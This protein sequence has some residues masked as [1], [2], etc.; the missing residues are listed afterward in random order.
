V[1]EARA[2]PRSW[3]AGRL[4][5]FDRRRDPLL[6][7]LA[8]LIVAV[9]QLTK[10]LIRST[11]DSGESWPGDGF[12]RIVHF[13][14]TGAAFGIFQDAGPLLAIT[15]VI[16][17]AAIF[18]YLFNPGFAHL[19]T[20]L[21][22][23]CMLGGAVGNLIDRLAA[24]EVVDFIKVSRWPAFNVADSAITIGVLLLLWATLR[25]P[26]EPEETTP[27]AAS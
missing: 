1:D 25:P 7:G 18:V 19:A 20:R 11:L 17:L 14:N 23:S 15:T 27:S 10:W 6:L 8:V 21:G 12:V 5:P 24:G 3:L 26:P 16:G 2:R 4:R 13:T 22:L 9:D